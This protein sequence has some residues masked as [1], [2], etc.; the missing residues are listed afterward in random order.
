MMTT[1]DPHAE[2]PWSSEEDK[3]LRKAVCQGM[4]T[5]SF[6]HPSYLIFA[7]FLRF[8]FLRWGRGGGDM[9]PILVNCQQLVKGKTWGGGLRVRECALCVRKK[10]KRDNNG[11]IANN[12][13][14]VLSFSYWGG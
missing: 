5:I 8:V 4:H 1:F 14:N 12:I 3:Q 11:R 7:F 10:G 6:S 2:R 9:I 13:L